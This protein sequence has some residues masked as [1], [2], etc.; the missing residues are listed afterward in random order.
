MQYG[1]IWNQHLAAILNKK[2]IHPGR[3][4]YFAFAL[5][6]DSIDAK[7][8]DGKQTAKIEL[9]Q[10]KTHVVRQKVDGAH[11]LSKTRSDRCMQ[12]IYLRGYG[13]V[14]FDVDVELDKVNASSMLS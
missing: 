13:G 5:H 11:V 6:V 7:L 1:E 2:N 14:L 12:A 4:L 8:V 3:T 10:F 9:N